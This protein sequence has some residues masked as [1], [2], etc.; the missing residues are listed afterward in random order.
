MESLASR[1]NADLTST[2]LTVLKSINTRKPRR[3]TWGN[4]SVI[5]F[6]QSPV[7]LVQSKIPV[8][9]KSEQRS[10]EQVYDLR[11]VFGEDCSDQDSLY[12]RKRKKSCSNLELNQLIN[13]QTDREND[14]DRN[15][16]TLKKQNT[17]P[18]DWDA[19]HTTMARESISEKSETA[20]AER[21]INSM[22]GDMQASASVRS[23]T[24]L[25]CSKITCTEDEGLSMVKELSVGTHSELTSPQNAPTQPEWKFR[26]IDPNNIQK[27]KA[28][29]NR[30]MSSDE[31][32]RSQERNLN[33]E[34]TNLGVKDQDKGC[35]LRQKSTTASYLNEALLDDEVKLSG[36]A[37]VSL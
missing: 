31:L 13:G 16:H 21:P 34:T 14:D 22:H 7:N 25:H 2:M 24:R 12:V 37:G 36:A 8:A 18:E 5:Y 1:R 3:V 35:L 11:E 10:L 9:T 23:P 20:G 27:S 30:K 4:Q 15:L 33:G 28:S 26:L 29:Q 6:E 17:E 32:S 19:D